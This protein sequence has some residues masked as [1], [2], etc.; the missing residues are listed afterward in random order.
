MTVYQISLAHYLHNAGYWVHLLFT[1]SEFMYIVKVAIGMDGP[2]L[3]GPIC[4][5]L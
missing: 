3:Y 2:N 5:N 1:L 4:A